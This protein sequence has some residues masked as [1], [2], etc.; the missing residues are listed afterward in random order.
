MWA[1]SHSSP[2]LVKHR[3]A[4]VLGVV[5]V[6][7][8]VVQDRPCTFA[9]M[10][11]RRSTASSSQIVRYAAAPRPVAPIIRIATPR[12]AAPKA[13][14]HHRRRHSGASGNT[15]GKTIIGAGIGGAV[16]GFVEKQWPSFPTVPI[17][18]RA[19]TIA[20]AAYFLSKQG[21]MSSPILRDVAIAGAVV[22]GYQLG[23]EGKVSGD[24]DVSGDLAEQVRGIAAQV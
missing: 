5:L 1:Y 12:A 13:K 2:A 7:L 11:K 17:L 6:V 4:A 20:V 3:F 8:C 23:K 18:G 21:G 24:D 22:A 16:L 19:G 15:T 9:N 10:A 14:K